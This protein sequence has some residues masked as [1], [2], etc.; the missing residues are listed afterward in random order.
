MECVSNTDDLI[1]WVYYKATKQL[2]SEAF[3]VKV[4][5][6]ESDILAVYSRAAMAY[7][8][9]SVVFDSY[10]AAEKKYVGNC[11]DFL[12]SFNDLKDTSIYRLSGG[13]KVCFIKTV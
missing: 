5:M 12:E 13:K 4:D 11:K 8:G 10:D 9:D 2:T 7:E 3:D 1:A 6:L